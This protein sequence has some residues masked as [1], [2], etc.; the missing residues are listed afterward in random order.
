MAGIAA[1]VFDVALKSPDSIASF[2]LDAEGQNLGDG[3]ILRVAASAQTLRRSAFTIARGRMD[4][5]VIQLCRVGGYVGW[6]GTRPVEVRQGDTA[7]FDMAGAMRVETGDFETISLVLPRAILSPLLRDPD[8]LHGVVLAGGSPQGA[9]L[10]QHLSSLY[11]QAARVSKT[12][13]PALLHAAAVL[14]AACTCAAVPEHSQGPSAST[15]TLQ[16]IMHGIDRNL[17]DTELSSEMLMKQFGLSRAALYRHFTP[18]GGVSQYIRRQRL[19]R[20]FAE[21]TAPSGEWKR[22]GTIAGDW[23]FES[24]GAF[25]RSFRKAFG[26]SPLEARRSVRFGSTAAK[27]DGSPAPSPPC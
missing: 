20:C 3:L 12:E 8:S 10:N 19:K 15:P 24:E 6:I 7:I 14:I 2:W 21:I 23:G 18:F 25:R 26:I 27:T 17:A 13:A 4:H 5:Y 11:A 16:R 1:D 22:I 9:L